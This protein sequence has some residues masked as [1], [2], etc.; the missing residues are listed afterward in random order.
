MNFHVTHRDFRGEGWCK[1]RESLQEEKESRDSCMSADEIL[2]QDFV[3]QK[4]KSTTV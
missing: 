3:L 4:K 1:K 2:L